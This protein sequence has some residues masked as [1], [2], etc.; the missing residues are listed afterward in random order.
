MRPEPF[1][2]RRPYSPKERKAIN[3]VH[4]PGQQVDRCFLSDE[5]IVVVDLLGKLES[6]SEE[7][8]GSGHPS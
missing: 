1:A 7:D 5:G 8:D 4:E 3:R 2:W 6:E